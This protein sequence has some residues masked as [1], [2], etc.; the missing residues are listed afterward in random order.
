MKI[1][2]RVGSYKIIEEHYY[3]D[4][5]MPLGEIINCGI[6]GD[7]FVVG[8][9]WKGWHFQK[10]SIK[11]FNNRDNFLNPGYFSAFG[12]NQKYLDWSKLERVVWT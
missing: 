9:I 6:V 2:G 7:S 10:D 4:L 11:S 12:R 1:T 3:L 5:K 8:G